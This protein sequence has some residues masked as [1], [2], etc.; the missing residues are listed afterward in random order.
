[1]HTFDQSLNHRQYKTHFLDN[2]RSVCSKIS[3]GKNLVYCK[4]TNSNMLTHEN[5]GLISLVTW[6]FGDQYI[7]WCQEQM[8]KRHWKIRLIWHKHSVWIL[9]S[10]KKSSVKK[11]SHTKHSK[12]KAGTD[13]RMT[14]S[15]QQVPEN[16]TPYLSNE[17]TDNAIVLV[18]LAAFCIVRCKAH[19]TC[20]LY[21][22]YLKSRQ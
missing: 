2:L 17:T 5:S 4:R 3:H 9:K 21:L 11:Y 15:M 14:Y 6:K 16:H 20:K 7:I 10:R 22:Y 13:M 18:S 19:K 1:M 8:N 12:N